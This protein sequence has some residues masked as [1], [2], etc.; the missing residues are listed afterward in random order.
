VTW[1]D[2]PDV[3]I[4]YTL[5]GSGSRSLV[6]LHELGG[7]LQTWDA[8]VPALAA[9]FRV[10]RYDQRGAG[11]SGQPR[12]PFTLQDQVG[13]LERLIEATGLKPPFHVVGLAAGAAIAVLFAL[14]HQ[15]EVNSL[16]LCAPALSVDPARREYLARRSQTVMQQGMLAV[17]DETL[18]RSFPLEVRRD[19][20]AY[21]K[22]RAQFLANDPAG[23]AHAN[24]AFAEVQV[25]D[26]LG[27]LE[28]PCLLLA[29]I[30]D[31]LRPPDQVKA[32]AAKLRHGEF[33][34]VDSG[35]IMPVQAASELAGKLVAFFL[36]SPAR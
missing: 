4:H 33:A 1:A 18:Q 3:R 5:S 22:Y 12:T 10:L 35:H 13:D 24:M 15:G 26:V 17:A 14:K 27:K 23:Y 7:S 34:L 28:V 32:L 29:G 30:H 25:L 19:R 6:L 16:A 36:R 31:S 11:L 21:E 9:E 2:G 8:V 20:A